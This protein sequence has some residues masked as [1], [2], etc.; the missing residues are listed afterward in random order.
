VAAFE[1]GALIETNYREMNLTCHSESAWIDLFG[2][3][4]DAFHTRH[5]F[6]E[7]FRFAASRTSYRPNELRAVARKAIADLHAR[8]DAAGV[9]YVGQRPRPVAVKHTPVDEAP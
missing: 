1:L 4:P 7:G 3:Q 5:M 8:L 9:E 2:F 6:T